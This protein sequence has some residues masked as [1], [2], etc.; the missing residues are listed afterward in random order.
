L[1]PDGKP[2]DHIGALREGLN[3]LTNSAKTLTN[4]LKDASLSPEARNA[5]QTNLNQINSA[6]NKTK[7]FF[8]KNNIPQ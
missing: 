8:K 3:G 7:I 5:I 6:I 4:A 2:F 1:R